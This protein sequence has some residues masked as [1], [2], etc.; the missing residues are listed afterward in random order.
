LIGPNTI[1]TLTP[2][3]LESFRQN[4]HVRGITL[5][6]DLADADRA[7]E[8]LQSLGIDLK[9]VTE[10]LQ[11]DA[12]ATFAASFDRLLATLDRKRQLVKARRGN[13][14]YRG[15]LARTPVETE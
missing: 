7:I 12:V 5:H 4:G 11:A 13:Y 1:I 8:S 9:S 10:R 3:T 2:S 15:K 6:D 14:V